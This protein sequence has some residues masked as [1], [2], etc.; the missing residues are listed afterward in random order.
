MAEEKLIK[1]TKAF[2]LSDKIL[3]YLRAN[4]KKHYIKPQNIAEMGNLETIGRALGYLERQGYLT[5][6]SKSHGSKKVYEVNRDKVDSTESNAKPTE[7]ATSA[8]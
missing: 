4:P 2:Q 6:R 1:I 3:E 8:T 5:F 7:T